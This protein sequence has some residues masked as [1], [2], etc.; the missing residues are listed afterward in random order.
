MHMHDG[1]FGRGEWYPN[2]LRGWYDI[3]RDR[4][5]SWWAHLALVGLKDPPLHIPG[6]LP[7]DVNDAT[8]EPP[9]FVQ[10][11]DGQLPEV[12]PRQGERP[13]AGAKRRHEAHQVP[14]EQMSLQMSL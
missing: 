11:E 9:Q 12:H 5:Q 8:P 3:W 1:R 6:T 13:K 4:K 10:P 2:F 14:R 7:D